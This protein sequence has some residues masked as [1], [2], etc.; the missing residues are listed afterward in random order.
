MK[1]MERVQ[2]LLQQG[3]EKGKEEAQKKIK[4]AT[5]S[6]EVLDLGIRSVNALADALSGKSK[7]EYERA[8]SKIREQEGTIREQSLAE[9]ARAMS[10][11][12]KV[13]EAGKRAQA[14]FQKKKPIYEKYG[15][16]IENT[17]AYRQKQLQTYGKKRELAKRI[18]EGTGLYEQRDLMRKDLPE[19]RELLKKIRKFAE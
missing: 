4:E 2:G 17:D 3:L 1:Q 16:D 6:G 19:L 10:E 12:K 15:W 11:R 18:A 13:E 14:E 5:G 9:Q 7:A 8:V